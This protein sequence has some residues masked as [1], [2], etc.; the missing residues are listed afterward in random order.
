VRSNRVKTQGLADK[1]HLLLVHSR[2]EE[3]G[4][5]ASP[6]LEVALA[7][8][9][10]NDSSESFEQVIYDPRLAAPLFGPAAR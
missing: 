9:R 7:R 8:H 1:E 4:G 2:G 6:A 10:S 5:W 3:L